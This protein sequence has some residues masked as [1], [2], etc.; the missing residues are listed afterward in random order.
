VLN[1]KKIEFLTPFTLEGHNFF[2]FNM[3]STILHEFD[4]PRGGLQ[5]VFGYQKQQSPPLADM[6]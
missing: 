3:F 2:K 1:K 6:L 5:V 4:A